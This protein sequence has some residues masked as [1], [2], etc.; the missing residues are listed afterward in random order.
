MGITKRLYIRAGTSY[1][2]NDKFQIVPVNTNKP[3]TID[4]EIGTFQLLINI[5]N[6]DGSKPH[7]DNSLY[8]VGDK[9]LLNKQPVEE[10]N[11]ISALPNDIQPNLRIDII[12]KP[13]IPIEGSRLIFGN[14]LTIPIR[15][16]VPTTILSA[17]LKFFTW[18]INKT[19]KGDLYNDKPYLYGLALNT[20][21]NM[22][23]VDDDEDITAIEENILSEDNEEDEGENETKNP[24][25]LLKKK[26]SHRKHQ[27]VD[28]LNHKENLS[29]NTDNTLDIPDNSL[30]RIKYFTNFENCQEF[31]FNDEHSKSYFLQFDTSFVKMADSKYAVSIPTYGNKT[32]DI[33]V[34]SLTNEILNN[35]NWVIKQDGYDGVDHGKLGLLVNFALLDEED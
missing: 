5:K 31:I 1:D 18:F 6:F 29:S 19:V 22:S 13:K 20:F 33:N 32:F 24:L 30:D 26:Q 25:K 27:I 8:N 14:D 23:I 34:S 10:N 28:R 17:G 12:F 7:L 2:L 15:D 16:Y 11:V 4:S 21:T 35:F 3:I 9:T